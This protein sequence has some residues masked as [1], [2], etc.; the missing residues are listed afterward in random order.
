MRKL[1]RN[2]PTEKG[3]VATPGQGWGLCLNQRKRN[4][5]RSMTSAM[6]FSLFGTLSGK[7]VN[8]TV[9]TLR[10]IALVSALGG[11]LVLLPGCF[12]KAPVEP[13]SGQELL[14]KSKV[15]KGEAFTY[16]D[17][18]EVLTTY[19]N[20]QGL[21]DYDG[22]LANREGLDRFNADLAAVSRETYEG[23]S[24]PAQ[25]AFW[26]NAYNS[27]TLQAIIDNYPVDS[28]R[29]INGVWSDIKFTVLGEPMTLND[30]EHEVL[31]K[32]FNEPRLHMAI[33]C[34]SIG[35]P[36]LRTEP[37]VAEK[38]DEQLKEQT[39]EFLKHDRNFT[40]D[41]DANEVGVSSIFKWFGEDFETTYG[42]DSGFE[43]HNDTDRSVLNF[44][45]QHLEEG[46]REYLEGSKYRFKHLDYDW[47]INAQ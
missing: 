27:L 19:V 32:D 25:I 41:K 17:Y 26:M 11:S 39:V 6:A 38:L 16:D 5:S 10:A 21:V 28:I 44:I 43:G 40:L 47:G 45:A 34:A 20:D 22:L 2:S 3:G 29:G 35:C 46:D 18:A 24:E 42:P 15:A 36:V 7:T 1:W 4:L 13:V 33:V 31:R 30:I 23:W 9:K 14:D 8:K 37:F 12:G